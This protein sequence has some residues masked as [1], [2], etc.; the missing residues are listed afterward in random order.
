MPLVVSDAG[1]RSLLDLCRVLPGSTNIWLYKNNVT[2]SDASVWTDFTVANYTGAAAQGMVG[3]VA[4]TTVGGK[5]YTAYTQRIF[6][7]TANGG[8]S[9]SIYGYVVYNASTAQFFWAERFASGPYTM[10]NLGD[11]IKV[12]PTLT[13]FSE[14]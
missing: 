3:S 5:A 14:Y 8:P 4:A 11:T 9:N 2:P 7:V 1:E 10:A 12:T 6:T 13:L